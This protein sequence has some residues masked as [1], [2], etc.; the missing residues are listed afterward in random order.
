MIGVHVRRL[1]LVSSCVSALVASSALAQQSQ[2][3]TGVDTTDT[4]EAPTSDSSDIV[5]TGIRGS[6]Q[7]AQELKRNADSVVEAITAEDLGKFTDQSV[8]DSLQ[9]VPGVQL[10]RDDA[11]DT[12]DRI[13]IRGFGPQYVQVGVNG[14]SLLS[15][16][17]VGTGDTANTNLRSF[18]FDALPSEIISS[19]LIYKTPVA[20]NVESGPAGFVDIKTLRPLDHKTLSGGS[21]FGTVSARAEGDS[22][23]RQ[24]SPRVSGT[25]GVKLFNDTLGVYVNGLYADTRTQNNRLTQNNVAVRDFTFR[26]P[27]GGTT[28]VANVLAPGQIN[29]INARFNRRREVIGGGVQWKPDSRLEVNLDYTYNHYNNIQDQQIIDLKNNGTLLYGGVLN[30]GDVTIENG[31]VTGFTPI[32]NGQVATNVGRVAQ[33]LN[34]DVTN[35][36]GGANIAWKDD[37]WGIS[38]D[39]GHSDINYQQNYD[40]FF[41]T[42]PASAYT[43]T[44]R[45]GLYNISFN[46][47]APGSSDI[48]NRMDEAGLYYGQEKFLKTARDS[49]RLDA[50]VNL[51]DDFTLRFGARREQTNVD[52]RTNFLLPLFPPYNGGF[53]PVTGLGTEVTLEAGGVNQ[54]YN[55][56][57]FTRAQFAALNAAIFPRG[58]TFNVFP[59]LGF[60]NLPAGNVAAG[61]P[62]LQNLC[63]LSGT[64]GGDL[65]D[66]P[67]P[68]SIVSDGT[69]QIGIRPEASFFAKERTTAIYGQVDGKGELLG[70]PVSGNLGIRAFNYNVFAQ[71]FVSVQLQD[72]GFNPIG[73]A[74][75]RP[76]RAR[77][78]RWEFLPNFN[79]T[80]NPADNIN[81]RLGVARTLSLPQYENLAPTG[82]IVLFQGT[83]ANPID[84]AVNQPSSGFGNIDLRPITSWNYDLT[85]EYYTPNRGALIA[86]VFY[87]DI[88]NLILIT[89]TRTTLPGQGATVFNQVGPVNISSGRA[90]GF[91][92]GFNQPLT[93]LAAPFDGFGIQ[94]NYTY[95]DSKFNSNLPEA[96]FGFVGSSKHNF[97]GTI[98]YEKSGFGVRASY[99]YRSSNLVGLIGRQGSPLSLIQGPTAQ[100]D[101]NANYKIFRNVE[102][103]ASA[104]NVTG[105]DR[106]DYIS[107]PTALGNYYD[108]PVFYTAGVRVSF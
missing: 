88:S 102:I 34:T 26:A 18:N 64:N 90:Y 75:N 57:T 66:G 33:G 28:T 7:R 49:F 50:Y 73:S 24:V 72:G 46:P 91:E 63:Q 92:V 97:N 22:S 20:Q 53:D 42:E 15:Y 9:R 45:N 82:D 67:F 11:G 105:R 61:C 8:A 79:L 74:Q 38:F 95:V 58:Q 83:P 56:Q 76:T 106:R 71:A 43:V 44:T 47:S 101:I 19:I 96:Q 27:G 3:P 98:Y 48:N 81:V 94:G 93:F 87:K 16:G 30:P 6:L 13:S 68:T 80:L 35:S 84:P 12:G 89:S 40:V 39:Y 14:R 69:S 59:S 99:N 23:A 70:V 25:V 85:F 51:A 103:T 29:A 31:A 1:A 32:R 104:N 41:D 17:D 55:N 108:R 54:F 100:L 107:V 65:Y 36:Y 5:V 77:S 78:N 2:A 86:S 37:N 62:L 4:Q 60:G 21:F 10:T 52:S